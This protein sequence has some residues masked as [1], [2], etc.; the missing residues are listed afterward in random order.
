MIKDY[1]NQMAE[2]IPIVW[3]RFVQDGVYFDIYGW[4]KRSDGER[5]FVLL[6][7]TLK[8]DMITGGFV[9]S[10]AKYSKVIDNY[11][12]GNNDRHNDCQKIE[13][14]KS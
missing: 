10:S 11:M 8:D 5:D 4:I 14:L 3:D 6:Q 2:E 13:E 7:L 9:T 12:Y 1:I